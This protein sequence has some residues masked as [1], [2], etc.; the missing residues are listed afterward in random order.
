[1]KQMRQIILS[2]LRISY[3]IGIITMDGED[4]SRE[5]HIDVAEAIKA[6]KPDA[7]R[8]AMQRMLQ[9]NK[10]AAANYWEN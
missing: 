10:R 1:M 7:A 9:R 3:E 2:M 8:K 6:R 5:A 4:V